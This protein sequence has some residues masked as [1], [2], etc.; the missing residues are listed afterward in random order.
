MTCGP[1]IYWK[2]LEGLNDRGS[3]KRMAEF[4]FRNCEKEVRPEKKAIYYAK[5]SKSCEKFQGHKI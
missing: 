1:C 4:N 3:S 2:T 5:E